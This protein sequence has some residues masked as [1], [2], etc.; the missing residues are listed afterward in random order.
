[1]RGIVLAAVLLAAA[2]GAAAR[3]AVA[4][5]YAPLIGRYVDACHRFSAEEC[6]FSQPPSAEDAARLGCLFDQLEFRAGAG[7]AGA[8]VDW[9]ERYAATGQPPATGFP[10]GIADQ[11]VLMAAM[12]ACRGGANGQ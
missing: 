8:H 2:E 9:I 5:D 11:Q 6:T 12:I 1:M 7:T 10:S 4:E 3:A